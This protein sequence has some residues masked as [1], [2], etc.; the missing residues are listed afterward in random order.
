VGLS[1]VR[2][3]SRIFLGPHIKTYHD[4]PGRNS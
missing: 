3:Y 1:V 2:M 4:I